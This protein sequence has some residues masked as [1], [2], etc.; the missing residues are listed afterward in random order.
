MFPFW[1]FKEGHPSVYHDD[2]DPLLEG[3]SVDDVM[4]E[5]KESETPESG[6]KKDPLEWEILPGSP[7]KKVK[8][9]LLGHP[10]GD[11]AQKGERL[12]ILW[13][14]P[15]LSSDAI[16]SVAY[17]VEE[18]LLVLVMVPPALAFNA[19]LGVVGVLIALTMI[20]VFCYRQTIDTYPEGGGAY[21][22][23]RDNFGRIPSLV[24]GGALMVGY[25]LT[26]AVSAASGSAA[27]I[28]VF[29]QI[30]YLAL[31]VTLFFIVLMT[32][33]NLRG[34]R[35]SSKLFGL[36]TYLFIASMLVMIVTGLVK[37]ALGLVPVG[38]DPVTGQPLQDMTVFLFLRAFASGCSS[39]TGVEAVSNA[40]PNFQE[41]AQRNAKRTLVLMGLIIAVIVGGSALLVRL[42]QITPAENGTTVLSQV[43]AA[44]FG[45]GNVMFYVIQATTAL[46]LFMA[47]NTAYNGLPSL[48]SLMSSHGYLPHYFAKKGSRLV[49]GSGI[50]FITIC[51]CL[52]EV[53]FR[54]D[55]HK[56]IPLYAVGVFLSFTIAQAGMLR[57]W[58]KKKEGPWRHRAL[59]N[60]VGC[61]ITGVVTIVVGVT[62]FVEGAW[63]SMVLIVLLTLLMLSI[64]RHYARVRSDMTI[65]AEQFRAH[66]RPDSAT[67]KIILPIKTVNRAFLKCL[68]YALGMGGAIEVFHVSTDIR[69]T[70]A[71]KAKYRRLG[72]NIPLVV[73][74]TDYR[75]VNEVLLHHVDQEHQLLEEGQ[76][77]TVIIPQLIVRHWWQNILHNQTS[78][79]LELSLLGRRNVAV[80]M[81]PFIPRPLRGRES[82][83]VTARVRAGSAS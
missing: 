15:V 1:L 72:L 81:I 50:V 16:S 71:L 51:A 18:I 30:D 14:L 42:F 33:G 52:L 59:I 57:H 6:Q 49:Y 26:V 36:P 22:V 38:S 79:S 75:N 46:I 4:R 20:L 44:V 10:L 55:T 23:A 54:A 78:L 19:L 28:S 73:E 21:S 60:G 58:F 40:V 83:K 5:M 61:L 77:L 48:M 74:Y 32:I 69:R 56:L 53:I 66:V 76:S 82:R 67:T 37:N 8:S 41:P 45:Q 24:A 9:S 31:P 70:A 65:T 39:L 27:I 25:I 3:L 43:A 17:G 64:S 80:V 7:L 62:K 35:E 63:I 12:S 68:N 29:P 11:S 34:V 47:A 2:D 13:A